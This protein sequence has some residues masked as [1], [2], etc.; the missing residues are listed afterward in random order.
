MK[1]LDMYRCYLSPPP[2]HEVAVNFPQNIFA[3]NEV[4]F[5]Y[6]YRNVMFTPPSYWGGS[7]GRGSNAIFFY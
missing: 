5:P 2:L 4:I 7:G 6:Y 1:F 3:R